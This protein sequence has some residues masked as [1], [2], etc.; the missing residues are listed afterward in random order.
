VLNAYSAFDTLYVVYELGAKIHPPSAAEVHLVAYL[1]CLLSLYKGHPA[2]DWAYRFA[3]TRDGSPFSEEID[4]AIRMFSA[5]GHIGP[6]EHGLVPTER[7]RL[8]LAQL[9]RLSGNRQRVEYLEPASASCLTMPMGMIRH[10]LGQEPTLRPAT[11]LATTRRLLDG[12]NLSRLYEQFDL[13]SRTIGVESTDLLIPATV[14][15]GYLWRIAEAADEQ[16]LPPER[17]SV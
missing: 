17:E 6:N 16:R 3:G 10:A 1:A 5:T 14:W 7:G 9:T 2:D 15:L 13:L 11:R 12:P 4:F 8:E